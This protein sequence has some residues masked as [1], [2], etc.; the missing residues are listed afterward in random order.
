MVY[1]LELSVGLFSLTTWALASFTVN[2]L[3]GTVMNIWV[4]A[5]VVFEATLIGL[6]Y[7]AEDSNPATSDT[8]TELA[9]FAHI[10]GM[11]WSLA[12]ITPFND[13]FKQIP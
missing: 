1:Y 10:F 12:M 8:S 9:Y 2:P 11:V 7:A 3:F 13:E 5:A 4:K 6:V